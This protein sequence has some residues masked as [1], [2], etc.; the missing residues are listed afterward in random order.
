MATRHFLTGEYA[1]H[2]PLSGT[3]TH[4]NLRRIGT[5][6]HLMLGSAVARQGSDRYEAI[7]AAQESSSPPDKA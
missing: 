5:L 2:P 4:E 1:H 3:L 7:L 6:T